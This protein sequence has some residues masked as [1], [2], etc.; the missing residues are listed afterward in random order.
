MKL[1]SLEKKIS[2]KLSKHLDSLKIKK[3]ENVFLHTNIAGV[4]Q[5][6]INKIK[7]CNLFLK[8][9]KKKIGKNSI[10]IIPTYNYNFTKSKIYDL[11]KNFS[12]VG[13]FTNYLQKKNLSKQTL[14]PIFSHLILGGKSNLKTNFLKKINV[15]AFGENSIFNFLEKNKFK[16]ICFCC[17]PNRIT[18]LHY[19]EQKLMVPYRYKKIFKGK[20]IYKNKKHEIFYNY[21]VGKKKID[22]SIKEE[23]ILK[24]LK[25]HKFVSSKFGRFISY[26]VDVS[27]L[28]DTL[29][30]IMKKSKFFLIN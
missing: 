15:D 5:Y 12:E 29:T 23:N 3:N 18:Y 20:F 17:S 6:S 7:S 24:I 26:A 14:D 8:I 19:L 27:Y 1:S 25:T 10:I 2:H 30:K 21:F 4:L 13:Y 9:L 11:K 22:Y 28:T 16:I